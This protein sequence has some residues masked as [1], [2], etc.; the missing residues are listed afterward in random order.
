MADGLQENI[1]LRAENPR[2]VGGKKI[3]VRALCTSTSQAKQRWG[4][5]EGGLDGRARSRAFEA[6]WCVYD[7]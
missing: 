2:A 1:R 3:A 7:G 5:H 4:P 6:W